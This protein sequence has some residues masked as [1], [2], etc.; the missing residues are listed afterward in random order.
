MLESGTVRFKNAKTVLLK[1]YM[2]ICISALVWVM[3]GYG[4]ANGEVS[5]GGF[6]GKTCFFG[7]NC[8]DHHEKMFF[9]FFFLSASST[10]VSGSIA[11]R[12]NVSN[13]F[14]FTIL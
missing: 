9:S 2:D 1:N 14:C 10:I 13:Y 11:E 4:F 6:I 3:W 8:K 7:I 5:K 12:V